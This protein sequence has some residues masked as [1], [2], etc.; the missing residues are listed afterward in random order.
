MLMPFLQWE[1]LNPLEQLVEF[2]T[3]LT[4]VLLKAGIANFL[5]RTRCIC[6]PRRR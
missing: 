4:V 1:F 6:V 5:F 2:L 3:V